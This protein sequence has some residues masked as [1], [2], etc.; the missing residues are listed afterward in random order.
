MRIL[1]VLILLGAVFCGLVAYSAAGGQHGFNE[2]RADRLFRGVSATW[3][4]GVIALTILGV[5]LV[6]KK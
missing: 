2:F 4:M 1:G 6:R 5:V 3:S